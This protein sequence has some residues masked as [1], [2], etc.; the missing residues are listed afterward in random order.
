MANYARTP[1][2]TR[3]CCEIKK[4]F[5]PPRIPLLLASNFFRISKGPGRQFSSEFCPQA[6]QKKLLKLWALHST[7][8]ELKKNIPSCERGPRRFV[9]KIDDGKKYFSLALTA[10][11]VSRRVFFFE[12]IKFYWINMWV[13]CVHSTFPAN[14][15]DLHARLPNLVRVLSFAR[16]F[17]FSWT[18]KGWMSQFVLSGR[19][20]WRDYLDSLLIIL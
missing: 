6:R 4:P 7:F 14:L 8:F 5:L 3:I 1:A 15:R 2:K 11:L 20:K 16:T 13:L 9:V 17:N 10:L 18:K 12:S 19:Q